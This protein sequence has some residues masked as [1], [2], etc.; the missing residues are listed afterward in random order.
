[1][2]G[3]AAATA[4]KTGG[5]SAMP[6]ADS[7]DGRAQVREF[8]DQLSEV[9]PRFEPVALSQRALDNVSFHDFVFHEYLFPTE[10]GY[11]RG[12]LSDQALDFIEQW[13]QANPL[14]PE[15]SAWLADLLAQL[16]HTTRSAIDAFSPPE[17]DPEAIFRVVRDAFYDWAPDP[18]EMLAAY[19]YASQRGLFARFTELL[20]ELVR[21]YVR[22]KLAQTFPT[23]TSFWA[24]WPDWFRPSFNAWI[25]PVP[26]RSFNA[27]VGAA[28]IGLDPPT[29]PPPSTTTIS[30]PSL[31][32]QA[33]AP[34]MRQDAYPFEV[35]PPRS[36]NLGLRLV[37]RQEWQPLGIQKGEIVRTIPL[38][39][40]QRQRVSTKIVRRRKTTTSME[41]VTE[42]E[43]TTEATD[44][45]KD[46]S[47]IV[48]EAAKNS[49]WK[50]DAEV[51]GGF[52]FLGGSVS[53]S[54]GGSS[55][56]KSRNTSSKLSETMRKAA[57]KVRSQTKVVVSTETEETFE[58]ESSSEIQNPNNEMAVSYEFHTLQHQYEVFTHLAEVQSVVFVAEYLPAPN[59]IT[60]EWVR[61]HDWIIARHLKDESHR[62]TLN[63]LNQDQEEQDPVGNPGAD[64]FAAMASKAHDNFATFTPSAPGTVGP[65]LSIPDIYAEPQ[66]ILQ[67][68]LRARAERAR[69]ND[70]RR[71]RRKRLFDHI[72]QNILSYCQAIWAQEDPDQRIL[73]YKREGRRVPVEF[74]TPAQGP[75]TQV[76][77]GRPH[78]STEFT[79]TGRTAPLWE[80]IDPTGPIAYTGNYAVF[81]IR[82]LPEELP[83]EPPRYDHRLPFPD[84]VDV[85]Q[86]VLSLNAILT[87][88]RAP[89][90]ED[91]ALKDPALTAYEHEAQQMD[92]QTRRNL[93]DPMVLDLVSYLPRLA[94]HLV[95][96]Q[97]PPL[98]PI[99]L[100]QANGELIHQITQQDWA[101]YLYRKNCTRRLLVD[102]NNLYLSL[103]TGEGAALEPFKR[104]HRYIDVLKA[105]EELEGL[106]WKNERRERHVDDA[107]LFDPDIEKVVIIGEDRPV[108]AV[109][110][111]HAAAGRAVHRGGGAGDGRPLEPGASVGPA[112]GEEMPTAADH[113]AGQ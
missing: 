75:L 64:P 60:A 102:S 79:P 38:G 113:P 4:N 67:Q 88:L 49:N 20:D 11:R 73:R 17:S 7:N 22:V 41:S 77:G 98:P 80:I 35:F 89:W 39:P 109:A 66:R 34:T 8:T 45:T 13:E 105:Y 6:E 104:A 72:R 12:G 14:P 106:S 101:Q 70:L 68:E 112:A 62:A 24:D 74:T 86:V 90:V 58:S 107:Q 97:E 83:G 21:Q 91:G 111:A 46:S 65:G 32:E 52:S 48:R 29:D 43:T 87:A 63:E 16:E 44:T 23:L 81:G 26:I 82:P 55:D 47:E 100:R 53:T 57:S 40:S 9:S 37:Y 108:G 3:R 50:V 93:G 61:A 10:H 95:D 5:C 15:C 30:V 18:S 31:L 110:A 78:I 27:Q 33:L 51:H 54:V 103:R 71:I 92:D 85:Q 42:Q 94:P 1:M 25:E 36:V 59:E 56:R 28:Y 2:A 69:A 76:L 96:Y 19:I 99:V 84:A